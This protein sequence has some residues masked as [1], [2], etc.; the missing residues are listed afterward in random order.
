M[1][2]WAISSAMLPGLT[3]PPY[4][5][6]TSSAAA[7]PWPLATSSRMPL[8]VAWASSG[9]AT[10]AGSDRP[11]RFVGDDQARHLGR[12]Q[13]REGSG[14]LPTA[15]S[16]GVPGL[17]LLERLADADDRR[18][19]RGE[20]GGRL[21]AHVLVGLAEDLA[22]LGVA[23]DDVG[24]GHLGEHGRTDLARVGPFGLPV[25]VLGAQV[26][27]YPVGVEHGLEAAKGGEGGMN[28]HVDRL[29]VLAIQEVGKLL[30]GCDG[31]EMGVVH[32]PVAADQRLCGP[33]QAWIPSRRAARPGRSPCS[34]NSSDAPP[35]VDT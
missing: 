2:A 10:S 25:A 21:L 22:P 35:P 7:S 31:L 14:H 33:I 19:G 6:R 9:V 34:M 23:H 3:E 5:I 12:R 16:R 30:N 11:D 26:D 32:L 27:G 8:M 15:G 18:H 28:G 29:I 20:D 4:W 17:A 1:S 13:T 24:H